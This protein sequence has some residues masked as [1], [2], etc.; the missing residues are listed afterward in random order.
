MKIILKFLRKFLAVCFG[1]TVLR[2]EKDKRKRTEISIYFATLL[3]LSPCANHG[4]NIPF[5]GLGSSSFLDGGPLR[6][7]PGWYFEF[8]NFFYTTH[9]FLNNEGKRLGGIPSPRYTA[10]GP[11]FELIYYSQKDFLGLGNLGFDITQPVVFY[12]H[13]QPNKLGIKDSGGGL[14]DLFVGVFVQSRPFFR[15]DGEPWYVNR[16]EFSVSL[17]TGKFRGRAD[18]IN[19][20]NGAYWFTPYWDATLYLGRFSASWELHYLWVGKNHH[21]HIRAGDAFYGNYAFA[22]ELTEK[23][24]VGI[25]GYFLKQIHNDTLNGVTVPSS[26]ERVFAT[27]VGGLYTFNPHFT[28]VILC[29]FFWEFAVRNRP[30]GFQF[31]FR[32]LKH[33]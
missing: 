12:S 15:S 18:T 10:W 28:E 14:G 16:L 23:L 29:N 20:G 7:I 3:M 19:P 1:R 4:Y 9:R 31:L 22:Y 32:Y 2:V 8:Y 25:N 17:P 24:F 27:G 11:A 6:Q 13:I 5:V 33:F 21:T 30:Q 26:R